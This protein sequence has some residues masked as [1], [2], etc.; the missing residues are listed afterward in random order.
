MRGVLSSVSCRRFIKVKKAKFGMEVEIR[1][2][3]QAG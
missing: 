2:N 3:G 1:E